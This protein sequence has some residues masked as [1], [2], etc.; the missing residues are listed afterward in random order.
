MVDHEPQARVEVRRR[1]GDRRRRLE[2]AQRP[3]RQ[4]GLVGQLLDRAER[5]R[6][7]NLFGPGFAK[8][9]DL[10]QTDAEGRGGSGTP[11]VLSLS[12]DER[13]TERTAMCFDKFGRNDIVG[14]Y[15]YCSYQLRG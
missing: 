7:G 4:V 8:P 5:P 14:R 10:A 12:K 13:G 2:Q 15:K 9:V 6:G 11:F 3:R 1:V